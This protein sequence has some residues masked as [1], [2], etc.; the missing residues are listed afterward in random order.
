MN[1]KKA[2]AAACL[3]L[4]VAAPPARAV[5]VRLRFSAAVEKL[6]YDNA[7]MGIPGW[8]EQLKLR[9][10]TFSNLQFVSQS[11]GALKLGYGFEGE[12]IVSFSRRLGLGL[13][14]GYAYGS[15][16]EEDVLT[17]SIWDRVTYNHTKPAKVSAYPV[18]ASGYLFL[19][20]GSKLNFYLRAGAGFVYGKFVGREGLKKEDEAHFFYTIFETAS[21]RQPAYIG[22]LGVS[23]NFDPALGFFAEA[24]ARSGKVSGFTGEDTLKQPG[25]LYSYEEYIPDLKYWQAK[26][27]VLPEAPGGG[28]FRQVEEA[29]IDLGAYSVRL[30]LVIKF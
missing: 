22:G 4:L 21:A 26:I 15:L 12:I 20:V 1:I 30:G 23:F 5:D 19:P 10:E 24:D 11:I 2:W 29:S 16:P 9:T 27:H 8:A 25:R 17:V 6:R 14:G 13:S 3:G 18:L 28:N 7:D